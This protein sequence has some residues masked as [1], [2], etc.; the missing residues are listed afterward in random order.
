MPCP[1]I[2]VITCRPDEAMAGWTDVLWGS[3]VSVT[4]K[5]I[6]SCIVI[7]YVHQFNSVLLSAAGVCNQYPLEVL[8]R[9]KHGDYNN[10][11][12]QKEMCFKK[13]KRMDSRMLF[14]MLSLRVSSLLP[15]HLYQALGRK[16]VEVFLKN[17][18]KRILTTT[19]Y[20]L[21]W[22]VSVLTPYPVL[23]HAL[24]YLYWLALLFKLS[25]Q[26]LNCNNI[27][28]MSLA[29]PMRVPLCGQTGTML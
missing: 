19:L 15:K 13:K 11:V 16:R 12:W 9:R 27:T 10:K 8:A 7:A 25:M 21:L 4:V 6:F 22:I 3:E 28:G 23:T 17:I 29:S 18:Q 24:T 5:F 14:H 2:N 20:A 26:R 1:Y